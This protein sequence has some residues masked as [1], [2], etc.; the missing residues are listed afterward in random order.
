MKLIACGAET[1]SNSVVE[2]VLDWDLAVCCADAVAAEALAVEV[3]W[4][5]LSVL[6]GRVCRRRISL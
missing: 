5:A 4:R 1:G 6:S 2:T 3:A